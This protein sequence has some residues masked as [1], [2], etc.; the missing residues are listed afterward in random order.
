MIRLVIAN[1]RG[2]VAKTT[3]VHSLARYFGGL[4]LKTLIVDTDSQGSVGS[5]LG[6]KPEYFL[7]HFVIHGHR[8]RDCIVPVHPN[9]DVLCSN[10]DTVE[11]EAILMGRTGREMTFKILFSRLE[12]GYDAI[13]IDV[14]P[15]ITLLQTCGL[16]YAQQLLIPVSMDP[17]SVQGAGAALQAAAELN[18]LFGTQIRPVAFLPVMVD[19]RLQIT[20]VIMETL[21]RMAAARNIPVLPAIR[22]DASVTK[23][24][25]LRRFLYDADPKS[26]AVEDYTR[27]GA[28]LLELLKGQ[29]DESRLAR[30]DATPATAAD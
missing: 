16:I 26:K 2:G 6:A 27:A 23:A 28:Y 21:D 11:T 17:L 19:R 7:H 8:L 10:R 29:Y 13:L 22:T 25:R 30:A 14:A 1:Q 18:N 15:S 9:I 5:V 3:T 20:D 12:E 24:S 4:G